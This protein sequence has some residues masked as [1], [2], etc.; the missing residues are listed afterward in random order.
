MRP[1]LRPA[2]ASLLLLVTSVS[3]HSQTTALTAEQVVQRMAEMNAA[4]AANLR[5]YTGRREYELHYRGFPGARDADMLV[6]ARFDAPASKD[7]EVVSSSGSKFLLD[8][9]LHKLLSGE[10]EALERE[11]REETAMTPANYN[12]TLLQVPHPRDHLGGRLRLRRRPHRSRTRQE[13]LLL[14]QQ[15]A[16]PAP[17]PEGRRLLAS[18]AECLGDFGPP[19]RNRHPD[20]QVHRLRG[21]RRGRASQVSCREES[22]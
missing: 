5:A 20:H 13:P 8:H 10:K 2:I 16:D 18:P 11:N 22:R 1:A 3:L 7:F 21:Q 17:L 9:V 19:W 4:R 6:K 15:N 14:D 12:F